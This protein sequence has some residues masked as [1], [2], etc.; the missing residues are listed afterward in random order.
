MGYNDIANKYIGRIYT[1]TI[2][3]EY[4]IEELSAEQHRLN[5]KIQEL[6]NLIQKYEENVCPHLKRAI[7]RMEC[8]KGN[9]EGTF[10][11]ISNAEKSDTKTWK[12]IVGQSKIISGKINSRKK[13][14]N[15]MY[16]LVEANIA[17]IENRI[18]RC[19]IELNEVLQQI[20][21]QRNQY[22]NLSNNN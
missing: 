19:K 5:E 14:I 1:N 20:V 3:C 13:E 4:A 11:K 22:R 9:V 21:I 8:L 10:D 16:G 2:G 15:S 7:E 18:A 17:R 12:N 6:K